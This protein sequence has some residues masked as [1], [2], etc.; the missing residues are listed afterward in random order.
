M[1]S[2]SKIQRIFETLDL[3]ISAKEGASFSSLQSELGIPKSSMHSIL[4]ELCHQDILYYNPQTKTYIIGGAFVQLSARCMAQVNFV[5]E[6]NLAARNLSLSAKLT[7]SASVLRQKQVV[8]IAEHLERAG[9][10]T[11][12]VGLSFPAHTTSMGKVL[13]SSLSDQEIRSL[14][15]NHQFEQ[16]TE[17]TIK[18]IEELFAAIYQVRQQGYANDLGEFAPTMGCT[19]VPILLGGK[20]IA[21][22]SITTNIGL[23]TEDVIQT[24]LQLLRKAAAEATERMG[25]IFSSVDIEQSQI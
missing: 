7:V 17:H 3:V 10:R 23:L 18:N 4:K 19:A 20:A 21:A 16:Y 13:L 12:N 24:H 6:I 5:R 1:A 9:S 25:G 15:E 22:M 8:Y 2:P 11:I 14:Y